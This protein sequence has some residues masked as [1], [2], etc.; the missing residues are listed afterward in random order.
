MA[1]VY[2]VTWICRFRSPK[3][4]WHKWEWSREDRDTFKRGHLKMYTDWRH[5]RFKRGHLKMYTDWRHF[6]FKR[7]HLKMYTDWRYFKDICI[8][9]LVVVFRRLWLYL[10]RDTW[11]KDAK[12]QTLSSQKISNWFFYDKL[13]IFSSFQWTRN[14]HGL[15][16]LNPK[17]T[18]FSPDGLDNEPQPP[19]RMFRCDNEIFP[20]TLPYQRH[21]KPPR[22]K[23]RTP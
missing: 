15:Q 1:T 8:F 5:F 21:P 12:I 23:W 2:S 9:T 10:S 16:P 19:F 7:G 3:H 11:R 17:C 13:Y 6:K 20:L 14:L 18:S 22:Y 4:N